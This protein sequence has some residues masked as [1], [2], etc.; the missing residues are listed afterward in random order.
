MRQPRIIAHRGNLTRPLSK[1][2][3]TT[4]N[5]YKGIQDCLDRDFDVECDI[6]LQGDRFYLGHER[7]DTILPREQEHDILVNKRIWKHA[8][9]FEALAY[10]IRA[11]QGPVFWHGDDEYTITSSG[12]IWTHY[13]KPYST[14]S[15]VLLDKAFEEQL[16]LMANSRVYLDLPMQAYAICTDEPEVVKT[17]MDAS[18]PEDIPA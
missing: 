14:N 18:Y 12:H 2:S 7:P 9:N 4:E 13:N 11:G 10:M 3:G 1:Y 8:K 15:V 5:S 17:V 6:W 16:K